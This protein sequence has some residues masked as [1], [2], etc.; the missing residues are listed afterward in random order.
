M[1]II[2]FVNPCHPCCS[3]VKFA[4]LGKPKERR[5][6][7]NWAASPES[8][9][10]LGQKAIRQ[11]A[12]VFGKTMQSFALLDGMRIRLAGLEGH[13]SARK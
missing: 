5:S 1:T 9:P 6:S 11:N 10:G 4:F 12:I 8:L 2:K 7:T 13:L 3:V